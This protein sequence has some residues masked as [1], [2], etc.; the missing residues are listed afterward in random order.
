ME[1]PYDSSLKNPSPIIQ[2]L[3]GRILPFSF[4][5]LHSLWDSSLGKSVAPDIPEDSDFL[6]LK[7]G[8]F[9]PICSS[10]HPGEK[11]M[12]NHCKSTRHKQNTEFMAKQKKE[13]KQKEAGER[14]SR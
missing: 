4:S 12:T 9:Y 1:M 14:N 2:E 13:K 10:F 8:F 7:A 6:V 5:I 3:R 11:A